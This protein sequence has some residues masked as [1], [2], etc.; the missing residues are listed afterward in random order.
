MFQQTSYTD[1]QTFFQKVRSFDYILLL[2]IIIIGLLLFFN[3]DNWIEITSLGNKLGL[4]LKS[5]AFRLLDTSIIKINI[6]FRIK[7]YLN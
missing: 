4:G 2:C 5:S 6:V 3:A 1:Q 7:Y